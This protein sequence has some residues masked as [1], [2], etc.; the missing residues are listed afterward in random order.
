MKMNMDHHK[1]CIEADFV[2]MTDEEVVEHVLGHDPQ[3]FD[4]ITRRY[5][6]KLMAYLW[7]FVG[8]ADEA[9]DILQDV[10]VKAFNKLDTFDLEK[11]FSP[12]IYRISH[13]EAVNH[14]KRKSRKHFIGLEDISTSKDKLKASDTD[15]ASLDQWFQKELR[16]EIKDALSQLPPHYREIIILRYF[17]DQSY[18]EIGKI[19]DKPTNTVGTLLRRAKRRLLKVMMA[20]DREELS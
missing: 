12:W 14:L 20:M 7:R 19:L 2:D 5:Q 17:E 10:F 6:G 18:Q 3:C 8:D 16:A 4:E 11:K 9:S 13:N 1:L 15:D